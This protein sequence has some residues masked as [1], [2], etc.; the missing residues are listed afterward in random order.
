[1]NYNLPNYGA[2]ELC[3]KNSLQIVKSAGKE[4]VDGGAGVGVAPQESWPGLTMTPKEPGAL[5]G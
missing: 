5:Y 4:P 3:H 2:L 1:M